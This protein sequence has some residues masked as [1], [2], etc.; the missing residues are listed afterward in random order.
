M[1]TSTTLNFNV[2]APIDATTWRPY[3]SPTPG[4]RTVYNRAEWLSKHLTK[5]GTDWTLGDA[6]VHG[7]KQQNM[8]PLALLTDDPNEPFDPVTWGDH[9]KAVNRRYPE[10]RVVEIGN[11][12]DTQGNWL[13][14]GN[15]GGSA[16]GSCYRTSVEA[17]RADPGVTVIMGSV[18][19]VWPTGHGLQVLAG[20]L[21]A[22]G[23]D[24]PSDIAIHMYP[25]LEQ[26]DMVPQMIERVRGA[27]A[28]HA[29]GDPRIWVTE[30]NLWPAQFS[31]MPA[32]A[33]GALIRKMLRYFRDAGVHASCHYLFDDPNGFG[34]VDKKAGKKVWN[35][36]VR[37]VMGRAA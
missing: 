28:A 4:L 22:H 17:F 32:K 29:K 37:A 5:N 1:I 33:Q 13:Y 24:L 36:A 35:D 26:V 25:T 27:C 19:S 2:V 7:C 20:A 11:E 14:T 9:C 23:D 10:V 31:Q 15:R 30:W 3:W 16:A 21:R 6:W 8:E 18:Q 12:T 34:F